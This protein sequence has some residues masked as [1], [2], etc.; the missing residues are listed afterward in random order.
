MAMAHSMEGR[1]QFLDCRVVEFRA[2]L[3]DR[4]KMKVLNEKY[5]LKQA[6]R[7]LIP[8]SIVRRAK[9]P[10]PVPHSRCYIGAAAPD[11]TR[12]VLSPR[13]IERNGFFNARVVSAPVSKYVAGRA[14]N[15]IGVMAL[16][17][18]SNRKSE[19]QRLPM[20]AEGCPESV[21]KFTWH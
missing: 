21:I 1:Y 16:V 10:Y 7:N 3:P 13:A 14:S 19:I 12:E 17:E 18:L 6:F 4:L 9:R 5:L 8:E 11:H 15:V 2:R 20:K